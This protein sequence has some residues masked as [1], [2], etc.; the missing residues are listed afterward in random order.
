MNELGSANIFDLSQLDRLRQG[1]QRH[2]GDALK[3]VAQQFESLFLKSWL[4]TM[5]DANE[6]FD[7]G[8][9]FNSQSTKFYQGMADDQMAL[10]LSSSGALGLADLMVAQLAPDGRSQL[11][12]STVRGGMPGMPAA[13]TT[14]PPD[15][16]PQVSSRSLNLL[17]DEQRLRRAVAKPASRALAAESP[18][19][20][21]STENVDRP[22]APHKALDGSPEAFIEAVKPHAQQVAAKL[23]IP[24]A[25]LIAQAALETGWGRKVLADGKG[26]SSNNL[27]NIKADQRWQG[28]RTQVTALEFEQGVAVQRRSNFRVYQS[29]AESFQDLQNFLENSSRYEKAMRQTDDPAN[30]LHELQKAGYAT[31]P[32][33]AKKILAVLER[34]S[35]HLEGSATPK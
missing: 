26:G 15:H 25:V 24:V 13:A 16:I 35:A 5:R 19:V 29:F 23:G 27:F 17:D 33:Y 28:E 32:L 34:V 11:P 2:D 10:E 22:A 7:A 12:A 8:E 4:K 30:F 18:A 20:A 14:T 9:P 6:V 3:Q 31:D 1:A 21:A